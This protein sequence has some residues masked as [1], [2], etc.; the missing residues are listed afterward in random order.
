VATASTIVRT[1]AEGFDGVTCSLADLPAR[2][3]NA[4]H[5]GLRGE[6][7]E[8]RTERGH[9]A[10][11]EAELFLRE[12]H[13]APAFGGLV[14]QR[15]QL[16]RVREGIGRNARCR[17]KRRGLTVPESDRSRLVEKQ[18]VDVAGGFDGPPRHRDDVRLNHS[19]HPRDPDGRKEAA[20]RG[21]NEADEESDEHREGDWRSL[22]GGFDA[23]DR[24][25]KERHTG[26]EKDDG[27]RREEGVEG[28]LVRCLLT[29]CPFDHRDHAVEK[30][31]S[32]ICRDSHDEPVRQNP[33][34]ASHRAAVA[35]ALP[36]DR[37]ALPGDGALVHRRD[38][39]D[40]LAVDGN[41]RAGFAKDDVVF[42]KDSGRHD[43]L[44]GVAFRAVELLCFDVAS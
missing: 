34:S 6:R 24:V 9:V 33:R 40:D 13:D 5:S 32:G 1:S 21:G 12:N 28:K 4:A 43:G 30:G 42:S 39:F 11:A 23:V 14:R 41:E 2:E 17:Q 38:A 25:R 37:S 18:N 10:F 31:L 22:A 8:R 36:N 19:I 44:L 27:E 16:R 29:L 3:V 35:A 7:Y 26:E 15:R 20:N